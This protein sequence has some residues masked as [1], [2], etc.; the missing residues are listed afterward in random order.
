MKN[1]DSFSDG[2]C[3]GS[4]PPAIQTLWSA[5]APIAVIHS[6]LSLLPGGR[7]SASY[8]HTIYLEFAATTAWTIRSNRLLADF[9]ISLLKV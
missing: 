5:V 8:G 7:L 6:L 1:L 4:R 2:R 9:G 3:V